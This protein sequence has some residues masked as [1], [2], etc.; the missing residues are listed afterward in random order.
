MVWDPGL[1]EHKVPK[2]LP[3]ILCFVWRHSLDARN[4][5]LLEHDVHDVFLTQQVTNY[6]VIWQR[7]PCGG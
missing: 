2:A 3:G 4:A 7:P 1:L 6:F 5:G